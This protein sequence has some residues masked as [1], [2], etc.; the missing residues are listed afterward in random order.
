MGGCQQ[1]KIHRV[2]RDT[3]SPIWDECKQLRQ[4]QGASRGFH[5]LCISSNTSPPLNELSNVEYLEYQS[6]AIRLQSA[7]RK[8]KCSP[9]R[10]GAKNRA[11]IQNPI[12]GKVACLRATLLL[13]TSNDPARKSEDEERNE[14][15]L[16]TRYASGRAMRGVH[17]AREVDSLSVWPLNHAAR[18]LCDLAEQ[19]TSLVTLQSFPSARHASLF[20]KAMGHERWVTSI[21]QGSG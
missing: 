15:Q 9:M 12:M 13:S 17:L 6:F 19:S 21:V 14:V 11:R 7:F 18:T 2:P 5:L 20:A 16:H 4:G 8:H 3:T 1:D 10:A